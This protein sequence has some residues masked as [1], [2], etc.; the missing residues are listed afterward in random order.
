MKKH[1]IWSS[2]CDF[3]DWWGD[4]EHEYPDLTK[5][6]LID[7]MYEINNEYL[8]DERDNLDIRLNEDIIAIAD[9]GLWNGRRFGYKE[10][11]SNNIS[12]C[13]YIDCDFATWYIDRYNNL[14][15]TASHHDGTN[16]ITYRVWKEGLSDTQKNNF[17]DKIYEGKATTKDITRYTKRIGDYIN[18]VYGW[19]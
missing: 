5:D 18:K 10:L 16:Y 19:K 17:L 8:W 11:N 3:Q 14:C 12:D 7:L 4:L 2:E 15:C 9:L 6:E 13:L 1:I